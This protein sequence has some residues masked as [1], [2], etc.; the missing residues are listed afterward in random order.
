[1]IRG[2]ATTL[3]M[4]F[5]NRRMMLVRLPDR[6]LVAL[7]PLLLVVEQLKVLPCQGL[8]HGI[9]SDVGLVHQ[10]LNL[11]GRLHQLLQETIPSMFK[12]FQEALS[13]LCG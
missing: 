7:L 13:I 1:M 5:V 11:S 3:G 10:G 4:D 2:A 8:E 6:G 12:L 9:I